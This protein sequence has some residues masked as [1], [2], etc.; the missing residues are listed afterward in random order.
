MSQ[1][2]ALPN[3]GRYLQ[4]DIGPTNQHSIP[5]NHWLD[6]SELAVLGNG[7]VTTPNDQV[8]SEYVDVPKC[9]SQD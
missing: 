8:R 2:R 9:T 7:T 5:C 6:A 4:S 1:G 3:L